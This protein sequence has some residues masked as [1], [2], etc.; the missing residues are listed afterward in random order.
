ME[1]KNN[2]KNNFRKHKVLI[3]RPERKETAEAL[4]LLL[5]EGWSIAMAN[6]GMGYVEYVLC[7]TDY[8]AIKTEMEKVSNDLNCLFSDI[9]KDKGK[10]PSA[11]TVENIV[12]VDNNNEDDDKDE[13]EQNG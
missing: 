4:V 7:K 5:N 9:L 12:Y 3:T 6:A 10:Q 2:N 13:D 11:S 1:N 8:Q